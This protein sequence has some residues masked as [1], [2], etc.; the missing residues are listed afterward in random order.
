MKTYAH[1]PEL[2]ED[3]RRRFLQFIAQVSPAA[4]PISVMLFGQVLRANNLL[5]QAAEKN[6]VAAGLTWAKFRLLMNLHHAEKHGSPDG[7]HPSELSDTQ[8]I[9]RNT[10]SAL[11]SSL[12]REGLVSR[13]LSDHDRRSFLIRLT[14]K[15]RRVLRAKMNDQ[16]LFVTG[17][18]AG[19]TSEERQTLFELLSRLNLNLCKE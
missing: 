6:L 11:I 4:D 15:G 2:D 10:V 7:M 17:C 12:E 3:K 8:G 18:F 5:V 14:A 16:F 19:F 1:P 13:G 9:S